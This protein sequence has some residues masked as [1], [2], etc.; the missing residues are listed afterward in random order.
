MNFFSSEGGGK[1]VVNKKWWIFVAVTVPLTGLVL[2]AWYL[3]LRVEGAKERQEDEELN[4]IELNS[5]D[6]HGST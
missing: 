5:I 3:W 2:G 1:F 4:S 6:A